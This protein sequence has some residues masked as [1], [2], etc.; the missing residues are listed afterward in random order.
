MRALVLL[1]IATAGAGCH[2]GGDGSW[3]RDGGGSDALVDWDGAHDVG[4]RDSG[5]PE[6]DPNCH[7]DCT[8]G[9]ACG[10]GG[11]VTT[12]EF[13]PIPCD[14]WQGCR[15][16]VSYQCQRGCRI[17]GLW[18]SP[19]D[20]SSACEEN[21]PKRAGDPCVDESWCEPQRATPGT[22][23]DSVVNVYLRCDFDGGV[24]VNRDPPVV[25][26]WLAPCGLGYDSDPSSYSY[27][28][29][30]APACSGGWCVYVETDECVRQGCTAECIA[31][32]DCPMGATCNWGVCKPGPSGLVDCGL[33]CP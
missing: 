33:S 3:D 26:D 29:A 8:G 16:W 19:Y 23:C 31:D 9:S 7:Y 4:A 6:T 28:R 15:S 1:V 21:R 13:A 11:V 18:G 30:A 17:D 12:W 20:P 2:A 25:P 5:G 22:T 27:G 14:E 24:C 32:S 10:D